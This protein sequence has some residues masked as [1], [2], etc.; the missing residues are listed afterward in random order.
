[1]VRIVMRGGG[2]TNIRADLVTFDDDAAWFWSTGTAVASHKLVGLESIQLPATND[3]L[4]R[5]R[6]NPRSTSQYG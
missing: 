4:A 3:A 2:F 1:M 5:T 6:A